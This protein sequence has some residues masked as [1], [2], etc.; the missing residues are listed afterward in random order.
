MLVKATKK[1]GQPAYCNIGREKETRILIVQYEQLDSLILEKFVS[2][3]GYCDIITNG[4]EA[5]DAFKIAW[6]EGHPYSLVF[7]DIMLPKINGH[8][9]LQSIRIYEKEHNIIGYVKSKAIIITSLDDTD[10]IIKA[11]YDG[12]ANAYLIKPIEKKDLEM[13]LKN[14][15]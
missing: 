7:L 9:V 14:L 3:Y 4:Q 5:I 2:K 8:Q 1:Q 12:E 13:T 15:V 10:N 11:Y 6:E